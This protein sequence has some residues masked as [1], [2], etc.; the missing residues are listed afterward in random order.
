MAT[1]RSPN[2]F[3]SAS[4]PAAPPALSIRASKPCWL[5]QREQI[6]MEVRFGSRPVRSTQADSA[7]DTSATRYPQAYDSKA[8]AGP[9]SSAAVSVST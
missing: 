2:A 4:G 3:W 1:T 8:S 6:Q 9:T 5:R 7:A